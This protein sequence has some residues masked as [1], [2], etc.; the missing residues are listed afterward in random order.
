[1]SATRARDFYDKLPLLEPRD[2]PK[3]LLYVPRLG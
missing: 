1:M 3:E 2:S